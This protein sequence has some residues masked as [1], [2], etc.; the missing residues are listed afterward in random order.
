[1]RDGIM[2]W[3]KKWKRNGW[4]AAEKKPVKNVDLWR[5]LEV[6]L[7]PSV[8]LTLGARPCQHA[9]NERGPLALDGH[10][11]G[12]RR[13]ARRAVTLGQEPAKKLED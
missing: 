7:E 11:R 9:M 8:P 10:R 1:M 13:R 3:I 5:P 4:Q 12:T 2:K 6:V